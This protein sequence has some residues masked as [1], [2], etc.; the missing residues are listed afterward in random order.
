MSRSFTGGLITR[1][2]WHRQD[3]WKRGV[4]LLEDK[5]KVER[6]EI[7]VERSGRRRSEERSRVLLLSAER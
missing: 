1:T 2:G 7:I 4:E 6:S 3:S 5:L